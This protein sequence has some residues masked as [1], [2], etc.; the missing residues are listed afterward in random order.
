MA[1]D[2]AAARKAGYSES[3]ILQHLA[4]TTKFD[5]AGARKAGYSDAELLAHMSSIELPK[6]TAGQIP[7]APP[8]SDA[9]PATEVAA[10]EPPA[11]PTLVQK[12]VG[13]GET[14]LTVATGATTGT[15]GLIGGTVGGAA[16]A[17]GSGEYGQPASVPKIEG[18]AA[19][20]M[21]GLTYHPRTEMG[22]EYTGAVGKVMQ[23]V[24][25]ALPLT[26]ELG[27]IGRSASAAASMSKTAAAVGVQ[28]L[29]TAA[30]A[31]ADRVDRVLR[32]NPLPDEVA[33]PAA[34]LT[35]EQAARAAALEAQTRGTP[36]RRVTAQDGTEL[37]LP[38]TGPR[39]L[40][41]AEAAELAELQAARQA[42][43]MAEAAPA[44]P[45]PGTQA[46][47][48][49]GG[50]DMIAQR[51]ELAA[52]VGIEPTYGQ[53]TRD[54]DQLRFEVETAKGAQ[55]GKIRE[56]WSDQNEKVGK[57]FDHLVDMTGA[58]EAD[59][60]GVGRTVDAAARKIYARDKA[61]VRVAYQNADKSPE[62]AAPVV[63]E[64]AVQFLN[65]SAPDQAVS[66]LL[67][68]ARAHAV[69]L[70]IAA[71]DGAGGLKAVPT[72]VKNA[73]R[74]RR[75]VGSATDYEPTNIRNSTIIK[76]AVDA[77][78]ESVAGPMY[79][80]ARRL[81]E[82]LGNKYENRGV[83]AS[84][85][86]NKRGMKD[87]K[88]AVEDVFEHVILKGSKADTAHVFRVLQA[89][90]KDVPAEI[91]QSGK[92]AANELRGATLNWI[93][94]EAFANTA[95]DQRGNVILSVPKL[96]KA[97]AR[98]D[99]DGKLDMILGKQGAQHMRDLNDLAKFIYTAPPGAVNHSNTA[100]VLL[101]ALTEAGAMGSMTGLPVP[102]LSA[103]KML[104]A[105]AKNRAIEK[106]IDQALA[107]RASGQPTRLPAPPPRTLH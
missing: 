13:M 94:E 57:H 12:L 90:G 91:V 39:R 96:D 34:P 7:T 80:N 85:L 53:L 31:I 60:L 22:K 84:L 37:E 32:R 69:K 36:S 2:I 89:H 38:G 105:Q 47:G 41:E 63:L 62:A 56:R 16:G 51:R 3:E 43:E 18:E 103:L 65:D 75:A 106:R 8:G 97:I 45:T 92:Q 17:V 87:R 59:L 29:R 1:F 25:P 86:N 78:T 79:R 21:V 77:A 54:Q 33:P 76:G 99:K 81:R 6:S 11:D 55:G 98:L 101:A 61:Q 66:P 68:T 46:S 64:D 72:T 23:Q 14:A 83:V 5:L 40:T 26:A 107:G 102:V 42:A 9:P 15:L 73:E 44:T 58:Q 49:A 95:T 67:V 71:D 28:R 82:N 20:G 93:K 104:S 88:V 24:F 52:K 35:A 74:F 70:G 19:A 4:G 10:F 48:G 100:S 27:A 30:P 50:T